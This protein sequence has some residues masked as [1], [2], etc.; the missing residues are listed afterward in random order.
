MS[1]REQ[2]G[3]RDHHCNYT[4]TQTH[5]LSALCTPYLHRNLT[6]LSLRGLG[7]G[8]HG[9]LRIV[10]P[11]LQQQGRLDGDRHSRALHKRDR[12]GR[13]LSPDKLQ[14]TQQQRLLLNKRLAVLRR[15]HHP[16]SAIHPLARLSER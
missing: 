3:G 6:H 7:H 16:L 10:L 12:S 13:L 11:D 8:Q 2:E 5:I 1:G 4:Y 14:L 15:D 9:E